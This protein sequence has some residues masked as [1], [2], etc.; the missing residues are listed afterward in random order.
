MSR[1]NPANNARV[2]SASLRLGLTE[3]T[4]LRYSFSWVR[5]SMR[6]CNLSFSCSRSLIR[7]PATDMASSS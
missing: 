1:T 6:F 4:T 7:R 2:F 5:R 3:W